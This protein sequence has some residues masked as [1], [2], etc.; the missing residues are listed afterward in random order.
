VA[1]LTWVLL[2]AGLLNEATGEGREAT[3]VVRII[4]SNDEVERLAQLLEPDPDAPTNVEARERLREGGTVS[5][6]VEG[7]ELRPMA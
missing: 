5:L 4:L 7:A 1:L 6:T 3:E 2:E